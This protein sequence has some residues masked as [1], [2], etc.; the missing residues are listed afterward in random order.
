MNSRPRKKIYLQQYLTHFFQV[1]TEKYFYLLR[2]KNWMKKSIVIAEI[3]HYENHPTNKTIFPNLS[4]Y[5]HKVTVI[6][7]NQSTNFYRC[8]INHDTVLCGLLMRMRL[9]NVD[10]SY[11]WQTIFGGGWVGFEKISRL[12][13]YQ[14]LT[15]A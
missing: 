15:Q 7:I 2:K 9:H 14:C 4:L 10:L 11:F 6:I 3:Q 5:V 1:S 8:F 13:S 12:I